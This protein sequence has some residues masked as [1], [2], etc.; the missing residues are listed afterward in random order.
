[1]RHSD[2]VDTEKLSP[3]D[4]PQQETIIEH[5]IKEFKSR[6]EYIITYVLQQFGEVVSPELYKRVFAVRYD[7]QPNLEEFYLDFVDK[8]NTGRFICSFEDKYSPDNNDDSDFR[9][10]FL[11]SLPDG[12]TVPGI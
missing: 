4:V 9:P 3:F 6:K 11:V 8:N 7:N 1:M 5:L 2:Y 10:H 12:I